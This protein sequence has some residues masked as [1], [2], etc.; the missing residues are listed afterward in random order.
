MNQK[1]CIAVVDCVDSNAFRVMPPS[2]YIPKAKKTEEEKAREAR[3]Q[4]MNGYGWPHDDEE[5]NLCDFERIAKRL[6]KRDE[7]NVG[8]LT[9]PESIGSPFFNNPETQGLF[10]NHNP[11]VINCEDYQKI[12]DIMRKMIADKYYQ[13]LQDKQNWQGVLETKLEMWEGHH[14]ET[15]YNLEPNTTNMVNLY[16]PESQIW[17]LIRM[18]KTIDWMRDTIILY[19]C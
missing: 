5:I 19:N 13:I 1:I 12:I 6:G 16:E 9:I 2:S 15:P 8:Y 3:E 14:G 18:Y 10:A 4:L 7:F 11:R 17:D